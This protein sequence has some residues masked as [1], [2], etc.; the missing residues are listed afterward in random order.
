MSRVGPDS[1]FPGLGRVPGHVL[2][3]HR[4]PPE[5]T[6]GLHAH[7]SVE[8]AMVIAVDQDEDRRCF[9]EDGCQYPYMGLS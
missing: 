1:S 2:H 8:Q 7:E 6:R 9:I 3:A 5:R 4:G